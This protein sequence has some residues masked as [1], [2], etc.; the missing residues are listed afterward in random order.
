[1]SLLFAL[2]LHQ[3]ECLL[4]VL[5][6]WLSVASQEWSPERYGVGAGAVMPRGKSSEEGCLK[7][8][9]DL[10][11]KKKKVPLCLRIAVNTMHAR[12]GQPKT[13]TFTGA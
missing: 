7:E 10:K 4:F 9:A 13:S 6:V 2:S 5:G 12:N 1:M 8:A 11:I 3:E